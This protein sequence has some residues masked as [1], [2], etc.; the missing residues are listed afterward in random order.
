MLEAQMN[1][2]YLSQMFHHKMRL[3]FFIKR[4]LFGDGYKVSNDFD[5][6]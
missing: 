3:S 1:L 6:I 5:T 2:W 4:Q